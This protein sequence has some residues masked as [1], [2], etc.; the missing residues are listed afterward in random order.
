M[1]SL[2]N[3]L[4]AEW[5]GKKYG[6]RTMRRFIEY[7]ATTISVPGLSARLRQDLLVWAKEAVRRSFRLG[8]T[9]SIPAIR[10][11]PCRSNRYR[12]SNRTET[13]TRLTIHSS[14]SRLGRDQQ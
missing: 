1:R 3:W 13:C 6:L 11:R 10:A 2:S 14:A 5:S 4:V 8:D 9:R 12:S 7:H